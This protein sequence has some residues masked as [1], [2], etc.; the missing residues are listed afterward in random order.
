MACAVSVYAQIAAVQIAGLLRIGAREEQLAGA[1]IRLTAGKRDPLR[2]V[3][4]ARTHAF[5]LFAQR[6]GLSRIECDGRIRIA[7]RAGEF[8]GG[9]CQR[10]RIDAGHRS[11]PEF[12][13]HWRQRQVLDAQLRGEG[14]I[15]KI[16]GGRSAH[17]ARRQLPASVR[18][19]AS[20]GAGR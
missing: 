11:D 9:R 15:Q 14:T 5:E 1:Q 19:Q 7:R 12:T 10:V 3:M 16:A 2:G 18:A 17:H 4:Q 8:D 13:R 20:C 6:R